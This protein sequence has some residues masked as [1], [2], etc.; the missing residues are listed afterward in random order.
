MKQ[1]KAAHGA[2]AKA[3]SLGDTIEHST[4]GRY[5]MTRKEPRNKIAVLLGGRPAEKSGFDELSTGAADDPAR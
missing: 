3:R 4:E 2:S 1:D 5:L